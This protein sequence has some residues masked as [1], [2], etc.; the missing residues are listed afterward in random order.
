[1]DSL[2]FAL[3]AVMPIIILV[4]IGYLLKRMGWVDATFAKTA[5]KLVFHLFLPVMLFLNVYK[6]EGLQNIE[7]ASI[8]YSVIALVAVFL[9][10]IPLVMMLSKRGDQRGVLWQASFRSNYALIGIPLTQSLFGDAGLAVSALM[11]VAVIPAI[12]VLAVVCL[13]TFNSEGKRPSVKSVLLGILKNPLIQSVGLGI[14][15]LC[16]R[17]LFVQWGV[18]FR[19]TDI[20][21]VYTA[22]GWLS[23]LAT[24][25]ALIMLGAQ[26]EFSA[27]SSL[28]KEITFG[29]LMRTVIVPAL[30]IGCAFLFF[31]NRFSGAHFAAFVSVFATPVSVSSVPMTQEMGGDAALAGQLVV[32]TTLVSSLSIFTVSFLLRM[33]GV[34]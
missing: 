2:I 21:P 5:N 30:C 18:E 14:L 15:A 25:L 8:L 4:A 11:S 16:V 12:N 10:A 20:K 19:L 1:M 6:I 7:I 32:W 31:R 34:F 27:V 28:K 24:P 13:S 33:A 17:A 23:N 26:F 3:N 9:L 22:M 29:V